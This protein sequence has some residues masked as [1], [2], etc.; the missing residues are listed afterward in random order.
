MALRLLDESW[1]WALGFGEQAPRLI[2][3]SSHTP[4]L[5]GLPRELFN[6]ADTHLLMACKHTQSAVSAVDVCRDRGAFV[7]GPPRG[8]QKMC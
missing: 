5:I 7:R 3:F 8:F 1:R 4:T 2:G 6:G